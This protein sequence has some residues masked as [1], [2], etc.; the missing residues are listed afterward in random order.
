M[1][2]FLRPTSSLHSS[3]KSQ[4]KR[5]GPVW[6]RR[7]RRPRIIG[8]TYDGAMQS[9]GCAKIGWLLA[10]SW[11]CGVLKMVEPHSIDDSA[12]QLWR[13]VVRFRSSLQFVE[14]LTKNPA[15]GWQPLH[16]S[17]GPRQEERLLAWAGGR[18]AVGN[19]EVE[20]ARAARNW[21]MP[22]PP[23]DVGE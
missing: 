7:Q 22:P 17:H 4:S 14:L 21:A 2:S 10:N 13:L 12:T 15:R 3:T 11:S 18:F 9:N 19:L 5:R 6:R 8:G 16:T 1:V 20:S 23:P